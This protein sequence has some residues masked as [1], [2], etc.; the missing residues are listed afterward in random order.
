MKQTLLV[1][2]ARQKATVD[3]RFFNSPAERETVAAGVMPRSI[4]SEQQ[5][6]L[7]LLEGHFLP[8]LSANGFEDAAARHDT[9]RATIKTIELCLE[10]L[11]KAGMLPSVLAQLEGAYQLGH[12]GLGAQIA[13]PETY[14]A[15]DLATYEEIEI[16]DVQG[17]M[18]IFG[19]VLDTPP[20]AALLRS[21]NTTDY[22]ALY[23]G[24]RLTGAVPMPEQIH[25]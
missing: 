17:R 3:G 22:I 12:F 9:E 10:G 7:R 18:V 23:Q 16:V 19:E 8:K 13:R 6:A 5:D 11:Q 2:H 25:A 14:L 21:A 15:S 24:L 20:D 4:S 1:N